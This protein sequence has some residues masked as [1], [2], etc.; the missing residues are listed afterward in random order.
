MRNPDTFQMSSHSASK[1]VHQQCGGFDGS[2]ISQWRVVSNIAALII[3]GTAYNAYTGVCNLGD[4]Q[5]RGP[6]EKRK[7]IRVIKIPPSSLANI[8]T[9]GQAE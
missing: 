9:S 2:E 5:A 6:R 4:V 3:V 7:H 1:S 8:V